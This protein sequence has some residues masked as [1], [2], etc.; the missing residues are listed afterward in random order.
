MFSGELEPRLEQGQCLSS[1]V[2]T[3][4]RRS[5]GDQGAGVYGDQIEPLG[6]R[7]R[8]IGPDQGIVVAMRSDVQA[9]NTDLT[10][11]VVRSLARAVGSVTVYAS[12]RRASSL[13]TFESIVVEDFMYRGMLEDALPNTAKMKVRWSIIEV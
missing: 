4:Q 13:N 2:H 7:Q 12:E 5:L 11:R 9:R 8:P 10:D 1:A 6:D 3:G